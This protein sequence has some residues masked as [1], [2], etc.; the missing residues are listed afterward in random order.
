MSTPL[1]TEHIRSL[2]SDRLAEYEAFKYMD[3]VLAKV[4]EAERAVKDETR[5]LAKL[6]QDVLSKEA[7]LA[8]LEQKAQARAESLKA[9][10]AAQEA[11]LLAKLDALQQEHDRKAAGLKEYQSQLKKI[12]S[13]HATSLAT[14]QERLQQVRNEHVAATAKLSAVNQQLDALASMV[15]G[16]R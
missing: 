14:W 10:Y 6:H 16:K 8:D 5:M 4:Q 2:L 15:G 11:A 7:A 3:E 1:S 9:D 13:D 12:E